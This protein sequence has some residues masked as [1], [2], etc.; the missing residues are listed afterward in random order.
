VS[1]VWPWR[2]WSVLWW[3]RRKHWLKASLLT[4]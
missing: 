4:R 3:G 1:F 2:R